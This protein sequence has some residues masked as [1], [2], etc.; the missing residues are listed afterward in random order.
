MRRLLLGLLIPSL[1]FSSTAA[2]AKS[3][4]QKRCLSCHGQA[5]MS[6]LDLRQIETMK[7]GGTRGAGIVPG[8]AEQSLL[9][10][11]VA[12]SGDLK[13]PPGKPLDP[14]EIAIIRKWIDDGAA[15]DNG[16]VEESSWWAFR[17]VQRPAVPAV[18]SKNPVD[19]FVLHKLRQNELKPVA[20]PVGHFP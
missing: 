10:K 14:E 17:K 3:V 19:S 12:R 7:K 18:A 20:R 6:G 16:V 11:A 5:Q 1:G 15:W 8:N 2:D 9:Y 13:M 4:L